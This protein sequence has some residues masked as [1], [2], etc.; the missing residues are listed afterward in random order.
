MPNLLFNKLFNI[1]R[2]MLGK[3]KVGG[4][5]SEKIGGVLKKLQSMGGQGDFLAIA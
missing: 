3:V 4:G 2:N 5:G 1:R